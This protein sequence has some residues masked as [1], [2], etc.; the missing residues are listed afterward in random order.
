M[1]LDRRGFMKFVAGAGLGVMATPIPWKLLDDAAIWTQNWSWIPRN[2][3][4]ETSYT[5]AVSKMCPSCVPMK[6]R[7]VGGRPV[8]VL[9]V[10]GHPLGGGVSSIAV[11]EVQMMFSPGRVKRPLY[12]AADGAF[13]ELSWAE[14]VTLLQQKLQAAGSSTAFISGD[15]NGSTNDVLSAF[16]RALGAG[17]IFLMP[18]EAQCAARAAELMGIPAQLG[19]DLENSDY[20]LAIGANLLESW[21]PVIRNRRIFRDGRPV[22]GKK[23]LPAR[24]NIAYAGAVQNNTAAVAR[25]WLPVYPGTEGILALGIANMLIAKGCS[26]DSP[27]FS[28]F[29]LLAAKYNPEVTAKETGVDLKKLEAV[30]KALMAAKAPLV[31]VGSE[32]SQGSGAAPVMAG[33]AL[34]ALLGN[35]NKSGGVC[36]LPRAEAGIDGASARDEIFKNDLTAWIAD[37]KTPQALV[38]HEANPA[39]ALPG[40]QAVAAFLKAV[41]FKVSFSTYMDETAALCDL[42]LPIGMGLERI[43]DVN[44]PYGCGKTVYC[45]SAVAADPRADVHNTANVILHVAK[46]MGKDLGFEYYEDLLKTKAVRYE[47]CDFAVLAAGQ[48]A[49]SEAR[50]EFSGFTARADVLA[51]ALSPKTR[52]NKLGLAPYAKLNLGTAKTGIPPYNTKTLR[53]TELDGKDMY[54]MM[55]AKTARKKGL[56]DGDM[57]V[58]DSGKQQIRARLRVFEGVMM[59]TVAVCLGYGHTALDEFSQNK[60]ANVMELMVAVPEPQTGLNVWSGTGVTVS[61]A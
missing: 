7:M 19:Y 24:L 26:F 20:V 58:L 28:E 47:K 16:A 15:E 1:V 3:K 35:I 33:F 8:R 17:D 37:R 21:G 4:G 56:S 5:Y 60:G 50:V 49:V 41:P 46:E 34:N 27:D 9:P 10:D 18:S 25:P 55:N 12:R 57:V 2:V 22:A 6:V 52:G 53:G 13:R 29:K 51:K 38:L 44:T 31:I 11:A 39:Y 43:D 42:V 48:A 32:F 30:V 61:K 40:P 54:V 14:A 23:E 45:I 59:D 36:L